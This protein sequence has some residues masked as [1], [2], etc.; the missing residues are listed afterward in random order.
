M[1]NLW[2]LVFFVTISTLPMGTNAVYAKTETVQNGDYKLMVQNEDPE[3]KSVV[4]SYKKTF[5]R[6][7]AQMAADFSPSNAPKEVYLQFEK[8]DKYPVAYTKKNYI[9][10]NPD[11]AKKNPKDMGILTHELFHVVDAYPATVNAPSWYLEGMAELA[12]NRYSIVDTR[13]YPKV[14]SSQSY[15]DSYLVTARFFE[16]INY[17]Q[18]PGSMMKIHQHV[19]KSVYSDELFKEYTGKTLDQLWTEYQK[20]PG[21]VESLDWSFSGEKVRYSGETG[22]GNWVKYF[23]F[24]YKSGVQ[25]YI[26]TRGNNKTQGKIHYKIVDKKTGKTITTYTTSELWE[27]EISQLDPLSSYPNEPAAGTYECYVQI[28]KGMNIDFEFNYGNT[29]H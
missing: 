15:R 7:Y 23:D 24:T 27:R 13:V 16:W 5:Q 11:Y 3:L 9:Y 25:N 8:N 4:N 18:Y 21:K 26:N 19:Q 1:K 10:V 2:C 28:P 22:N 14:T 17:I 29:Y 20:N 6:T 12:R